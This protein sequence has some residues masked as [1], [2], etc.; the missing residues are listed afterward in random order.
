MFTP[1][2]VL[3]VIRLAESL[4]QQ[5][6]DRPVV[7]VFWIHTEDHDYEE[8]NH[9]YRSFSEKISYPGAFLGAVGEHRLGESIRQMMPAHFPETLQAC[10]QP[11]MR[12]AEASFRFNHALYGKYGLLVLDASHPRLKA[13]FAEV[14]REEL[15]RQPVEALVNAQSEAMMAAAYPAQIHPR[16]IN[17]FY[18][19]AGGR[20]R[21][22]QDGEGFRLAE[23]RRVISKAEMLEL[24]S[25][26]PERFSPNVCLRPLYQEMILPNLAY[27]GGWAE[28]AYW[29]QLKSVFE[30]YAVPFPLL[31][32]RM[33]ATIF[34][35]EALARW[36]ALGFQPAAI[37][38]DLYSLYQTYLD[39][40]W[41]NSE[42]RQHTEAVQAAYESLAQYLEQHSPTLPRA[43]RGQG[44]KAGHFIHNLDKKLRRA[45]REAQ[46][47]PYREIAALKAAIQP[48]G[49]V[50]ERVLGI[51][52]FED[53]PPAS[54]L[55][56]FYAHCNPMNPQ[57]LFLGI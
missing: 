51:A 33:S 13:L 31:L 36:Q 52:S 23:S 49:L 19:D 12:L 21:I 42:Y 48:D 16:P 15:L 11:G 47:A 56:A 9:Y 22:E 8:I 5:H 28:L 1:Y 6:P 43:A 24:V 27:C 45:L 3:T 40:H 2:K 50:Q 44:V 34:R 37:G 30:H 54:L 29:M 57:H 7:P 55:D 18:M 32:P 26:H 46:P 17:L 53:I 41:D 39:H 38:Q 35:Y 4:S 14:V 20:R 25:R 10:Y